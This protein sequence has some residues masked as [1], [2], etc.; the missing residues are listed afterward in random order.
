MPLDSYLAEY[1]H[2][3]T[4]IFKQEA[5]VPAW[6]AVWYHDT[7]S[8]SEFIPFLRPSV[9]WFKPL[10]PKSNLQINIF[11]FHWPIPMEIVFASSKTIAWIAYL[12]AFSPCLLKKDRAEAMGVF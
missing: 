12:L 3:V 7:T 8:F 1:W 4:S 11:P 2:L 5:E 9:I 10:S 6:P